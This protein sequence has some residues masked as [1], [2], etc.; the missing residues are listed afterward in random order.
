MKAAKSAHSF[1]WQQISIGKP[2]S[3]TKFKV[4][5]SGKDPLLARLPVHRVCP[6]E[7]EVHLDIEHINRKLQTEARVG[8]GKEM[9]ARQQGDGSNEDGSS[10]PC[11][12]V[13]T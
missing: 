1:I 11:D 12:G 8:K 9:V 5:K 4:G 2:V 10:L 3:G 13:V 6:F 7:G